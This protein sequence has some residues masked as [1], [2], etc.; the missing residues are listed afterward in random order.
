MPVTLAF[1]PTSAGDKV[2][3]NT[4]T[5]AAAYTIRVDTPPHEY[6]CTKIYRSGYRPPNE[7]ASRPPR[8]Y[9]SLRLDWVFITSD[10]QQMNTESYTHWD[11]CFFE[12]KGLTASAVACK[13][14][15][16]G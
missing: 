7:Q 13:P 12:K 14:E 15:G 2:W 9:A 4:D 5:G 16:S 3:L 1:R 8:P 10:L 11:F 6:P